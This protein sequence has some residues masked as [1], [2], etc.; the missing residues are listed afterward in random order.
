MQNKRRSFLHQCLFDDSEQVAKG[1]GKNII[2]PPE[3]ESKWKQ[4]KEK[5][6]DPLIIV[7]E[8]VFCFA[9]I[10]AIYEATVGGKGMEA[11]LDLIGIPV[12]ILLATT[13]GF[14]FEMKAGKEF[15]I[16]IT[17]K[18]KRPVKVY[19]RYK[20]DGKETIKLREVK[21]Q[22]VCLGDYIYLESGDEVPADG[23]LCESNSLLVDESNFTGEQF[24]RKSAYEQDFDAEA[25]FPTN[26]VL[27]GSTVIDG[28]GIFR[29]TAIGMD[30][31]EGKG[32]AKTQ[33][34]SDVDTP[35][36]KQLKSLGSVI[37]KASFAIAILIVAG[38]LLYYFF[39]D[40]NAANNHDIVDIIEFTLNSIMLAVT[41][42]VVAVPEGLPMSVT[43]SLAL[44]MRKMLK[45]NNLVRKLHACETMGAA[46]V[47]CTDKT[48]T[49]TQN[50]MTVTNRDFY[51]D[52]AEKRIELNIALNSTA[53]ISLDDNGKEKALGNPTEGALLFWLRDKGIDYDKVRHEYSADNV[54]PFSTERKY[55]ESEFTAKTPGP[56]GTAPLHMRF[57]KGAPEVVLAMSESIGNGTTKDHI[58][59]MLKEYQQRAMR[60]L[61]FASQREVDGK[62]TPLTFDGIVG[63][64]DPVRKDV[65]AAISDCT[66]RAGVRVI[67]VTG[68]NLTTA[69][70]IGRQVG[71]LADDEK[72]QTITGQEFEA[73]DDAEASRLVSNPDFKIISR[74]RPDDKARLVT[75]LQKQDEVVAVT[76]DGTNDAPALSKAQ[77]GLSM[78][79]GTARAKEAS[80]ITIIDNSFSSIVRAIIWGR[81]LYLNIQRFILFQMTINICACLIVLVGAFTGTDSPLTVTQMLWVNL[82]MDTFAAGALSSLP[83]DE[84]VLDKKPRNPNAFIIDRKMLSR[85]IGVGMV[86]FV[87]LFGLWQLLW[88]HDVTPSEG[89]V[90]LFSADAMKSAVGQYLDF[91]K[92]KPHIS[93][94]EM[95]IFFSFFV[96]MQF[97]NLFNAKYFRT[98][99]SLLQDLVDIFRNRQAVAKS[100][101]KGF[102]GV[103]LII[104]IGQIVLV[105]LDGVMFNVAPLTAS[106]WVYIIIATSPIAFVPDIIRTIQNIISRPKR[107]ET[108]K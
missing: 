59:T 23:E 93:A 3:R 10:V 9:V 67:I 62:W 69:N 26:K 52:D 65:K 96:F 63:I 95:G 102:I 16:L 108:S 19:R 72:P 99:R 28:N 50:K 35:L 14:F 104:S 101:S 84:E 11:F 34:G 83:A 89:F 41:L 82:I 6:K 45:E 1:Q 86:F 100:Y 4:Y 79:A 25:T 24:A 74:A 61:A 94:Y 88:H 80:D 106:D 7:L 71:L 91:S 53:E 57:I 78:G 85:I 33:E 105:N 70:E 90:S 36:N 98:G 31:V 81:S 75:L 18:D 60:T 56:D 13:V 51:G 92:A 54:Q 29:V 27:R 97:W 15:D 103:M 58:E 20:N 64:S 73:M 48:G 55:M 12:A 8:V 40:G 49:L 44:S 38:R 47:I 77:V 66:R 107:K 30:T 39:F 87:I 32:A 42:I 21:R 46:T 37:S 68:D 5:F 43:I 76:G 2:P 22:N 17:E